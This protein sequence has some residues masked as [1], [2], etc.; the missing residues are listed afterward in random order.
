MRDAAGCCGPHRDGVEHME[1]LK[2]GWQ[3]SEFWLAVAAN[4]LGAIAASGALIENS[5]LSQAVGLGVNL[6]A[7]LGYTWSRAKAKAGS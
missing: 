5:P 6:L 3:T 4:I 2:P 1:T 7:T